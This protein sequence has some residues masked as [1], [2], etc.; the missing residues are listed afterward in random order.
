MKDV[1][2]G[3]HGKSSR[4]FARFLQNL[5]IFLKPKHSLL[6]YFALECIFYD[7]SIKGYT[8]RVWCTHYMAA[9]HGLLSTFTPSSDCLGLRMGA[10]KVLACLVIQMSVILEKNI[11]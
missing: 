10:R 7:V 8:R 4:P 1:V 9:F 6:A 11:N 2:N 5:S 3:Q